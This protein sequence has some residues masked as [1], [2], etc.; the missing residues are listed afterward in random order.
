MDYE[1]GPISG[2][3]PHV[4][5]QLDSKFDIEDGMAFVQ[6]W[7]WYQKE[8]GEIIEDSTQVGRILNTK[9]SKN[10]YIVYIDSNIVAGQLTFTY[11][12]GIEPLQF[13]SYPQKNDNLFLEFH[14]SREGFSKIEFARHD[15]QKKDSILFDLNQHSYVKIFYNLESSTKL[16]ERKGMINYKNNLVPEKIKLYPAYPNPFNP[17]TTLKFDIPFNLDDNIFLEVFDVRGSRV[18]YLDLGLMSPGT[19][20]VKWDGRR[21]S[22]GVYIIKLIIGSS[23]QTQKLLLIK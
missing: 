19:H 22:S 9:T 6:M 12:S 8:F 1:I 2:Q 15:H 5:P 18:D 23:R 16:I 14:K 11:D 21:H 20:K 4:I 7:S 3:V 17:S 13:L 10:N